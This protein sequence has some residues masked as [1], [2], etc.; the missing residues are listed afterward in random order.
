MFERLKQWL[1][2]DETI[3]ALEH[4]VERLQNEVTRLETKCRGLEELNK[5]LASDLTTYKN[6]WRNQKKANA[7]KG[8]S[9]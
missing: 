6:K 1:R 3:E 9:K 5:G 4:E 7:K 8:G 2:K